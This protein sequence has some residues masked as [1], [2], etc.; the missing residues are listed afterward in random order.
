MKQF[1]HNSAL[2]VLSGGQDSVTCLAQALSKYGE[3]NVY[4]LAFDYGQLHSIELDSARKVCEIADV[5]LEIVDATGLL[6]SVSPLTDPSINLDKYDTFESMTAIVADNVEKTFVPMRNSLFLTIAFNHAYALNCNNVITGVCQVD[7]ANYPDCT[8]NFIALLNAALNVSLGDARYIEIETPLMHLS[9]AEIS[10][11][12]FS[13]G[14]LAIAMLAFSH[15][16]YDGKFPP[17]DNNH[18]N[19]LRA[20]GYEQANLPDPLVVRAYMLGLMDLPP[21]ANY[22]DLYEI[23]LIERIIKGVE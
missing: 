9:K 7:G 12:G 16:S 10:K 11:L 5:T 8:Q 17:T 23:S 4:A 6:K 1:S 18:S 13:F 20:H 15:T 14:E 22:N 21:T 2:V 3:G 19:I